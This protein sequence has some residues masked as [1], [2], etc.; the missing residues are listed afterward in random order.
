M[1]AK[2]LKGVRCHKFVLSTQ[3]DPRMRPAT[4]LVDRNFYVDA[5]NVLWWQILRMSRLGRAFFIW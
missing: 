2:G 1:K 5:P 3:R 4:D